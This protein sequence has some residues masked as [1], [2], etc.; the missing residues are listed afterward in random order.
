ML[1]NRYLYNSSAIADKLHNVYRGEVISNQ[2]SANYKDIYKEI[3]DC[4]PRGSVKEDK[5]RVA[6]PKWVRVF[7]PNMLHCTFSADDSLNRA[8]SYQEIQT[9][10]QFSKKLLG[11]IHSMTFSGRMTATIEYAKQNRNLENPNDEFSNYIQKFGD[12]ASDWYHDKFAKDLYAICHPNWKRKNLSSVKEKQEL[13]ELWFNAHKKE[14]RCPTIRDTWSIPAGHRLEPYATFGF[15]ILPT[16][17][18]VWAELGDA[19]RSITLLL[20]TIKKGIKPAHWDNFKYRYPKEA[21]AIEKQFP[22]VLTKKDWYRQNLTKPQQVYVDKWLKVEELVSTDESDDKLLARLTSE[23][24]S[25]VGNYFKQLDA[26]RSHKNQKKLN[27][28]IVPIVNRLKEKRPALHQLYTSKKDNTTT[29]LYDITGPGAKNEETME[30]FYIL[31]KNGADRPTNALAS[32]LAKLAG[33]NTRYPEFAEEIRRLRPDWFDKKAIRKDAMDRFHKRGKY[34][35][36][37]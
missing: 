33:K 28:Y 9:K 18:G 7:D 14:K 6:I 25:L 8:V 4:F 22:E 35:E 36:T 20:P 24:R 3:L 31:A 30:Q 26:T 13:L 12:P 1:N 5:V 2:L 11:L 19:N 17:G 34:K 27:E 37:V 10:C 32:S 23:E 15:K 21:E 29:R 16:P